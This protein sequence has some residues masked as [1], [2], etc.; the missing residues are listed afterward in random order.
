MRLYV[1]ER[2]LQVLR[3]LKS[4]SS[5]L[6]SCSFIGCQYTLYVVEFIKLKV[7]FVY[8]PRIDIIQAGEGLRTL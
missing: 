6:L 3:P 7:Y 8:V 4:K 2:A 1:H 5:E